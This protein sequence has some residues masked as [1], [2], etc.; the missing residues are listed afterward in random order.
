MRDWL[1]SRSNGRAENH[2]HWELSEE[3]VSA[4]Y[5][6]FEPLA[7]SRACRKYSTTSS[8]NSA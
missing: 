3:A 4:S 1:K 6:A 8:A 7:S 5:A 2:D